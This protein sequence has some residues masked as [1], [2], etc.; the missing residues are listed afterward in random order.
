MRRIIIKAAVSLFFILGFFL[1]ASSAHADG[2]WSQNFGNCNHSSSSGECRYALIIPNAIDQAWRGTY[3]ATHRGTAGVIGP[4]N[5]TVYGC[6][7]HYG[8]MWEEEASCWLLASEDW[9]NNNNPGNLPSIYVKS[10]NNDPYSPRRIWNILISQD[11]SIAE[12]ITLTVEG[13]HVEVTG[14]SAQPD[15]VNTGD[16]IQVQW[17]ANNVYDTSRLYWEGAV[18]NPGEDTFDSSG[19]FNRNAALSAGTATFKYKAG[20]PSADGFIYDEETVSVEVVGEPPG[21]DYINMT[22]TVRDSC[23]DNPVDGVALFVQSNGS[24]V[25][26]TNGSGQATFQVYANNIVLWEASHEGYITED[27]Y[28]TNSGS[29]DTNVNVTLEREC[30]GGT[31]APSVTLYF[32]GEAGS[33]VINEG[34]SGTLSWTV[35][36]ADSCVASATPANGNWSGSKSTSGG[37]EESGNIDD[38]TTF[39]ITCSNEEGSDQSQVVVSPKKGNKIYGCTNPSAI[40]Y[41]PSANTDDGS[42]A[43]N[44]DPYGNVD[45]GGCT[46]AGWAFDPNSLSGP[47]TVRVYKDGHSSLVE[48]FVADAYRADLAAIWGPGNGNHAFGEPTPRAV[49]EIVKDG[50]HTLYFYAVDTT[51]GNDAASSFGSYSYNFLSCDDHSPIGSVDSDNSNDPPAQNCEYFGG[52]TYDP[53]KTNQALDVHIYKDGYAGSG[54]TFAGAVSANGLRQ[55]VDD[56]LHVGA[57]HGYTG[58]TPVSFKDGDLHT[59]YVYALNIDSAGTYD[60]THNALIGTFTVKCP[61]A[62]VDLKAKIQGDE[63]YTN[64][65]LTVDYYDTVTLKWTPANATSCDASSSTSSWSG[66]RSTSESVEDKGPLTNSQY[67]YTITCE[68]VNGVESTDSVTVNVNGAQ[69]PV[70][71]LTVDD[72]TLAW[73]NTG[74]TIRWT[75]NGN[76]RTTALNA[77]GNWSGSKTPLNSGSENTGYLEPGTYSYTLTGTGPGGSTTCSSGAVSVTVDPPT[78]S[79]GAVSMTQISDYCSSG[80]NPSVTWGYSDSS[81]SPQSAYEVQVTNNPGNWTNPFYESGKVLSSTSPGWSPGTGVAQFNTTYQARARVWNSYNSPSAWST[82]S[83][84]S[85]P[86][87]AYPDINNSYRPTW[88]PANPAKGEV[89][90]FTDHTWFDSSSSSKEWLWT[91]GDGGSS[92]SQN[93]SHTYATE[94]S[95]TVTEKVRD[96]AMPGGEYCTATRTVNVQKEIPHIKEVAPD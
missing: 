39:T 20:G 74:T 12:N 1:I 60:Y 68:G 7:T 17:S 90:Q 85:T 86:V 38:A 32:E 16:E 44:Q 54:G 31:P 35:S 22:F 14:L 48:S 66:A 92:T 78:P 70:C 43:T 67:I 82:S 2:S 36:N 94:T 47:V 81:D 53:D 77:T 25:Q 56:I 19:T 61:G 26:Y 49:P 93:P 27:G 59:G 64:G 73:N 88:F 42:C 50:T 34:K 29:S 91:F 63:T 76:P 84:W 15:P 4:G 45:I 6:L 40:N 65:P 3:Q 79:A 11:E 37:S 72:S 62:T 95:F 69:A 51:T 23:V 18:Q 28:I 80:P 21:P 87:H 71:A 24:S 33:A 5:I 41:N 58:S 55:D 96:N 52:W 75:S 57:Y 10:I 89:V 9:E 46:Y 30:G 83:T 8:E 13:R